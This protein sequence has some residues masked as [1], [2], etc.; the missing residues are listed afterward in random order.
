MTWELAWD[1]ILDALKDSALVLAFVFVIHVI[2]SFFEHQLANFLIKRKKTG[3]LFGALFGLVPQCGTSILGADLYIRKYISITTTPVCD[4]CKVLLSKKKRCL[5][6][7]Y[8]TIAN[9]H[10]PFLSSFAFSFAKHIDVFTG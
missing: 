2:I 7:I 3:T 6:T 10:F 4:N 1:I 9:W 5:G 8:M